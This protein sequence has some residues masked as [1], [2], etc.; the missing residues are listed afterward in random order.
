MKVALKTA[1]G[2]IDN[3]ELDMA[4]K[5]LGRAADYEEMMSTTGGDDD[6]EGS[7][8]MRR[9]RLEYFAARILLVGTKMTTQNSAKG[10]FL[11]KYRHGA[12]I[13]W[14]LQSTFLRSA[15]S[16]LLH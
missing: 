15:K 16:F 14:T 7:E 12:R 11:T 1:R 9:L 2:C 5:I 3:N 10:A 6:N 13:V 4:V 8:I